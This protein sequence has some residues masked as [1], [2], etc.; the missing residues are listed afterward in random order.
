[1]AIDTSSLMLALSGLYGNNTYGSSALSGSSSM[2]N[3]FQN[4][5]LSALLGGSSALTTGSCPYCAAIYGDADTQSTSRGLTS[6]G[7]GEATGAQL[8]QYFEEAEEEYGVSADLLRAIAKVGSGYDINA[9]AESG[10]QG[11]MQLMPAMA[12]QMDIDDVFDA[13]ENIMGAARSLARKLELNGGDVAQAVRS[14]HAADVASAHYSGSEVGMGLDEYVEKVLKYADEDL[15]Q[16][17][18]V[19]QSAA[20]TSGTAK[21]ADKESVFTADDAKYLAEMAKVQMQMQSMAAFNTS[22]NGGSSGG[23]I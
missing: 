19:S 16:E 21:A 13:R 15:T 17:V 22:L 12:E 2:G 6:T 5:L 18:A 9:E 11:L 4:I 10:A 23:L 8:N 3:S 20:K 1:M 14:Y 7:N